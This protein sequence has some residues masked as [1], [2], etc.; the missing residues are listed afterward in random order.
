[1]NGNGYNRLPP[2]VVK[3][4]QSNV[5]GIEEPIVTLYAKGASTREIQDHLQ[6]V[7]GIEV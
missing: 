1:M 4:H 2:L 7:C 5:T 3:K 6:N